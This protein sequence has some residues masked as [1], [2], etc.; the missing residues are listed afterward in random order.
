MRFTTNYDPLHQDAINL[1]QEI[2]GVYPQLEAHE[3]SHLRYGLYPHQHPHQD[4]SAAAGWPW[5]EVGPAPQN[6]SPPTMDSG[7]PGPVRHI[8]RD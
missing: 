7:Q 5:R 1:R 8:L 6:L 4:Y 2:L 3:R